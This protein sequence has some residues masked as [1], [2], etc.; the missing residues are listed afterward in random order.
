MPLPGWL[1]ILALG[2]F[3]AVLAAGWFH[4]RKSPE[5]DRRL[6]KRIT[7]LPF[8][9]KFGLARAMF[10]DSRIPLAVRVIPPAIVLYLAMPL[11]VIPDFI[12]VA[13]QLDDVVVVIVGVGL[14]FKFT[15]REIIEE[16]VTA[17]EAAG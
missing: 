2:A 11:D 5:E 6:I 14:L 9:A 12:P 1:A 4:W 17:L 7:R 13:G 10:R 8:A 16:H 15:R 3:L